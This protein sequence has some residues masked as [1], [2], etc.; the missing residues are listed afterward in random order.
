MRHPFS[1]HALLMASAML[2]ALVAAPAFAAVPGEKSGLRLL[3]ILG[4]RNVGPPLCFISGEGARGPDTTVTL[5]RNGLEI[6]KQTTPTFVENGFF[7]AEW[8][9]GSADEG[10]AR[11]GD[12][13][14]A[15]SGGETHRLE[16]PDVRPEIDVRA[17]RA[18]GRVP[19]GSLEVV[20]ID[21][22]IGRECSGDTLFLHPEIRRNGRWSIDVRGQFDI[23]GGD[24][25]G[26][27]W[28]NPQGDSVNVLYGAP[29]ITAQ[30]GSPVVGGHANPGERVRVALF[31][32]NGSFKAL[33]TQ[34]VTNDEGIFSITMSR[35]G[36]AVPVEIG[37]VLRSNVFRGAAIETIDGQLAVDAESSLINAVCFPKSEWHIQV[38]TPNSIYGHNGVAE[39]SGLVQEDRSVS[40]DEIP[41]RADD[42]VKLWCTNPQ[43]NSQLFVANPL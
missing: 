3:V 4:V 1:V 24:A 15:E 17:D 6:R 13:V 8:D 41:M 16:V 42:E 25:V 21:C 12:L 34:R 32:P 14:V 29:H 19:P 43:G 35:G 7:A 10:R 38:T 28:T 2:S 40:Q 22:V 30:N 39:L 37:D 23:Q 5:I 18:S 31:G 26:V 36:S 9:C 27:S 20:V 33:G 11:I